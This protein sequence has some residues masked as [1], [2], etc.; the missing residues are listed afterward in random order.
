MS[1]ISDLLKISSNENNE[2]FL[3]INNITSNIICKYEKID[4]SKF[5]GN[6]IIVR[7][8]VAAKLV[9]ISNKLIEKFP[10]YKL[11][12]VYGYR[13]PC[14]QIDY[15]NRRK[16]EIKKNNPNDTEDELNEKTHMFVADPRVAGH[17]TGGAV[18]ITITTP[19]GD[20]DMGTRIADFSDEDKIQT[21]SS[22]ITLE[23]A[24]NRKLLH[25]LMV[26]DE[27]A[28]FYGEWWHFS[29]G[30]LEWA[31]FYN[32]KSSL[33]SQIEFSL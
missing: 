23:Q 21:F 18:D 20:L 11:K 24:N 5:L 25:D 13:H 16:S 8:T 19:T 27:F 4:M 7:N 12:I 28:P 30:D 17:P 2:D 33:Y 10:N 26:E 6:N 9:K 32:H 29:Y 3:I 22:S 31:S 15:F 14:I 1:K